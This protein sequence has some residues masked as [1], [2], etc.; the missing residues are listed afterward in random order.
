MR[1]NGTLILKFNAPN[2]YRSDFIVVGEPV[3]I[4]LGELEY[5]FDWLISDFAGGDVKEQFLL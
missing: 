5:S 2:L 3:L 4:F 1:S